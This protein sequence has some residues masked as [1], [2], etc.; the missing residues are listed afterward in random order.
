M[1][2]GEP[3]NPPA[4][5]PEAPVD[6]TRAMWQLR[7][8]ACGLGAAVLVLSLTF[9]VFVWKQNRNITWQTSAR[10][11]RLTPLRAS[12][13][14]LEAALNELAR[15]S[16]SNPDLMAV[17]KRHG[18]EISATPTGTPSAPATAPESQ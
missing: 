5:S 18:A 13:Q 11:S 1:S 15:Y 10:L 6:V 4:P 3:I 14:R 2:D 8:V 12:Q 16:V 17:F 9:N 7:A